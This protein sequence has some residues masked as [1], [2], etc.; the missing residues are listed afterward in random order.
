MA[1]IRPGPSGR[2]R[3]GDISRTQS[4]SQSKRMG[5]YVESSSEEFPSSLSRRARKEAENARTLAQGT[6]RS[7]G[8]SRI[9]Q[10]SSTRKPSSSSS[11]ASRPPLT[12]QGRSW[13]S[14]GSSGSGKMS[15]VPVPASSLSSRVQD[16]PKQPRNVLRRKHSNLSQETASMRND[17][18]N[19]SHRSSSSSSV[20]RS[21]TS[22]DSA[23]PFQFDR[24]LTESPMEIQVAQRVELPTTTAHTVRIYPELDRYRDIQQPTVPD[25]HN[26]EVPYR[27]A[28][29]DLPP[30][31]PLFSGTS[32]QM[33]GFSGS[34]STRFSESPGPGPYS[35]DTTPTSISSQSPGLVAPMRLPASRARQVSPAYT[36]PPVT[37][38][39]AGS[40]PTEAN[41]T[42]ADPQG[43]AAVRESLTSSSSNSTV[44]DG[45]KKDKKKAKRLSPLPPSPPPR[46]SSQKFKKSRDEEPSPSKPA[47]ESVRPVLTAASPVKTASASRQ[48]RPAQRV[49]S[50]R[51]TPPIRPSRDGT[52]DLQSQLGLPM[53]IIHSNLSSASLSDRRQ[54]ATLI[55][56]SLPRSTTPSSQSERH[57]PLSR[58]PVGREPT[59]GPRP[60]T[61]NDIPVSSTQQSGRTTRTPS[62]SVTTFK[63]RFPLF[64]RRTKTA[65]EVPVVEKAQKPTRKG[66]AAGTGHEGYG[67]LG[68]ARRRSGSAGRGPVSSQESLSS[69]QSQDI[70]LAE[71]MN[72]VVISGGEIIENRNTSSELSRTDSNQSFGYGR[73]TLDS[74]NTSELSLSSQDQRSTLWPSAFPRGSVHAQGFSHRRP[75]D[76]SDSEALAM[77]ST[78][79][80]RRSVQRL[81]TADQQP[82]RLPKPIV[83]RQ[84]VTSPS[85]NSLDT[86]V[87]SDDSMFD[88]RPEPVRGRKQ[89]GAPA[90]KKLTKRAKSPRKWNFFGRSQSQPATA[91][92]ERRPDT[93][94]TVAATVQVMQQKPVAFYTMDFSEQEDADFPDVEEVLR[95]A[96]VLGSPQSPQI[97]ATHQH[98]ISISNPKKDT[99]SREEPAQSEMS[100]KSRRIPLVVSQPEQSLGLT[101]ASIGH[102]T[103]SPQPGSGRPSRL[104]Q[105]GR[106]PKVVS[107]RPEQTSPKSF[108]RPFNRISMQMPPAPVEAVDVDSIAKGASPPKPSSPTPDLVQEGSTL[109]SGKSDSPTRFRLSKEFSPD[110]ARA[111]NE[112][113]RF[114]PRFNSQCTSTTT[115]SSSSGILTFADATAVVPEVNAPLVED[116]IWD[117]YNDLLGEENLKVPPSAGSSQGRPFHLENWG[118]RVLKEEFDQSLESPTINVHPVTNAESAIETASLPTASSV[119]SQDM[120]AKLNEALEAAGAAPLT[121]F[122]VTEFVT[123]Y[124]DR[125]NSVDMGQTQDKHGSTSTDSK[126]RKA[127]ISV[128]STC[129][130]VSEDNSPLSQVN[131]RVGSMTVSKWLTFGH[132]LFSPARDDLV[133]VV[134]SLKRHSILVVDGLGN[135]DWS[136]YA[137]ETYPAATFFNLSP[138]APLPAEHQAASTFP[139]SPPNHHQI[140]YLSHD[141]KFPFGPQSF[142][143]V[144]YRFPAAAPEAHYRNIIT[145]ARRVLKPGG[146]IELSILDVDLNNMGNRSRRT[147]RRLKEQIHIE[148]PETS[149]G[150]T[151]DL[152]LRLLGRKGFSEIKTCRVGVPVASTIPRS[153]GSEG[154][155]PN[156]TGRPSAQTKSKDKGKKDDRSLAE[157][158]SDE[159]PVADENITKMVSKVGRW[160]YNRCYESAAVNAGSSNSDSMWNDR[161]LMAECEEWGTSLKLMVCHARVPDGRGRVASI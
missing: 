20:P 37:R 31:T 38:R 156:I 79:A 111:Q 5:A 28:T 68:A 65:P 62:P 144:V 69:G 142:T 23:T 43:L 120:T 91:P 40:V 158:M 119:Y 133:P 153:S 53:P 9:P 76:S 89:S 19:D 77:K 29:H 75:S 64:G 138:R 143:S 141:D 161:A 26:I 121:P 80:L 114:S 8:S 117:E 6:S 82:L 157:M 34:P 113:L 149:L 30:P 124:G 115:T 24:E 132:V 21:Q 98:R 7:T 67:R 42:S 134:G 159:S 71:R 55:T 116:E 151:A 101:Q 127:R 86:S 35:R 110:A 11:Q 13:G 3:S 145:E 17:S 54:S 87:M 136:F 49:T 102:Q 97:P 60:E 106:I 36:R 47:K 146:F 100:Q 63:T 52:P 27:I 128:A 108:S 83:V 22:L 154:D 14:I 112:F 1:S 50:P 57:R 12:H 125:N 107:A 118:K 135:D 61:A 85:V 15:S 96:H 48:T 126:R 66:P 88:P 56:S 94:P 41:D 33:S 25:S 70:F 51:A 93:A 95:D 140:Q 122:S 81:R 130:Q 155:V 18:R 4:P 99:L 123:G 46:K 84:G 45:E 105:V 92:K 59:P 129:S 109:T 74:Q 152:I 137:A 72:P 90:P 148:N 44:R 2:A 78:L 147:V 104:P 139:L 131:L 103:P 16:V 150:S 39:R 160:W 10:T 58:L 73:R 32:S